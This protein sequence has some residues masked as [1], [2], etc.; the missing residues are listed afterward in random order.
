MAVESWIL[1]DHRQAP[2]WTK[3]RNDGLHGAEDTNTSF[4]TSRKIHTIKSNRRSICRMRL[5][6]SA[7]EKKTTTL[8]SID[9]V[10]HSTKTGM[11][12]S[13]E[14]L[15]LGVQCFVLTGG[16]SAAVQVTLSV[17]VV[18][19]GVQRGSDSKRLFSDIS[20]TGATSNSILGP[21]RRVARNQHVARVKIGDASCRRLALK[22]G[23][24]QPVSC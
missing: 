6:T 15:R 7:S 16:Q 3:K 13:Q 17:V 22:E 4:Y 2:T 5:S 23:L 21:Q 8:R 12:S 14:L 19:H 11:S 1:T 10:H 24:V 9:H 20:Q 18:Q